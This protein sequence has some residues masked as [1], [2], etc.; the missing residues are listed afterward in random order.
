M[1]QILSIY[2]L[3]SSVIIQGDLEEKMPLYQ[4]FMEFGGGIAVGLCGLAAGFAIGIVGD[5]GG[6]F[7]IRLSLSLTLSEAFFAPMCLFVASSF[8][9]TAYP[10]VLPLGAIRTLKTFF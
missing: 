7:V 4:G 5:A 6:E 1:A 3:V 2:G 9:E 10:Q 8:M